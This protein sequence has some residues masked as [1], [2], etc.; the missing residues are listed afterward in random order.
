M[1]EL[2]LDSRFL[3]LLLLLWSRLTDWL[4][5]AAV[6]WRR[7][8][9]RSP[10]THFVF[11]FCLWPPTGE[12]SLTAAHCLI[13]CFCCCFSGKEKAEE[14]REERALHSQ[15]VSFHSLSLFH[16]ISLSLSLS[17]SPIL[18]ILFIPFILS[19]RRFLLLLLGHSSSLFTS[20]LLS[21]FYY[22]PSFNL[23]VSLLLLCVFAHNGRQSFAAASW[24][25]CALFCVCLLALVL[26]GKRS[27][28]GSFF[29]ISFLPSLSNVCPPL[30]SQLTV[31]IANCR[32]D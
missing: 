4:K 2:F 1:R 8:N 28:G 20:F 12:A 25:V 19:P 9:T 13:G 24:F 17:L 21:L 16:S 27:G 26:I 6:H 15:R 22:F 18:Q 11:C 31:A 10:L 14:R 5:R 30:L 29:P 3:L 32:I 7:L 23:T